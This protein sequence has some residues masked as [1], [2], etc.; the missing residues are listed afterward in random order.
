MSRRPRRL[1]RKQ[2]ILLSERGL[3]HRKYLLLWDTDTHLVLL[4]KDSGERTVV[5]TEE[6]A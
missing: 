4:N 2:K 3:D 1:T 5:E 6:P